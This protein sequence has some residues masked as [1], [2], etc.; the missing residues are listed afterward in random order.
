MIKKKYLTKKIYH[1]GVW[2]DLVKVI[3]PH[4]E[5]DWLLL[6]R[7]TNCVHE[8]GNPAYDYRILSD[9]NDAWLPD[10]K[11]VRRLAKR[12]DEA[13]SETSPLAKVRAELGELSLK[14]WRDNQGE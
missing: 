13:I 8:H 14:I 1:S 5:E 6:R 4:K 12:Y 11:Q 3:S 2:W 7:E 9:G 10:T